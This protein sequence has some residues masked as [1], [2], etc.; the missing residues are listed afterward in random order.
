MPEINA[1]NIIKA[2]KD[3]TNRPINIG[4]PKVDNGNGRKSHRLQSQKVEFLTSVCIGVA[5]P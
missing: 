1:I 4:T 3:T 5:F 2:A